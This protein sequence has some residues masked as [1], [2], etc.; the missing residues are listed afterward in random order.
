MGNI[1]QK[2]TLNVELRNI[3]KFITKPE[4]FPKYVYGYAHGKTISSN[5]TWV[6]ASYEWYGKS[7][8]FKLKSTE[9]IIRTS[10]KKHRH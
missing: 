4:N 3:W 2:V 1:I 7:D 5:T 10:F 6:G 9:K 8:P